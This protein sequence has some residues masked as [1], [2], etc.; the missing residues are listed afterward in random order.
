MKMFKKLMAVALAGVMALVVLT[1]CAS[2]AAKTKE[3]LNILIDGNPVR[4]AG[5]DVNLSAAKTNDDAVKVMNA[6]QAY[7]AEHK[8]ANIDQIIASTDYAK[9]LD[10]ANTTDTFAVGFTDVPDYQSKTM[11]EKQAYTVASGLKTSLGYSGAIAKDASVKAALK[12]GMDA[13]ASLVVDKIGDK[14]YA[15][16]V[17]R[18][19]AQK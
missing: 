9:A 2:D 10:V 11:Q 17:V 8:D 14:T 7:Q 1:G 15:V 16:V 12:N 4:A 5:I 6:L 3:I 18:I 13:T 19:P